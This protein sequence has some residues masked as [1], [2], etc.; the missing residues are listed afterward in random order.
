MLINRKKHT[1]V[2]W[3]NLPSHLMFTSFLFH[4]QVKLSNTIEELNGHLREQYLQGVLNVL[5]QSP[6]FKILK[7]KMKFLEAF[8]HHI[9][10]D[11]TWCL[12]DELTDGLQV[13][14]MVGVVRN[15]RAIR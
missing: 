13:T 11:S 14:G 12:L 10:V 6:G 3:V 8:T 4:I 7:D 1:L 9:L 5:G 15:H 2:Y